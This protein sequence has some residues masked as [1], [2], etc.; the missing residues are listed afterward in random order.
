M[1]LQLTL[2]Q[3]RSREKAAD[4]FVKSFKM[5]G[6]NVSPNTIAAWRITFYA[7]WDLG[8]ATG[9]LAERVGRENDVGEK[10]ANKN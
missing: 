2:E 6:A 9:R 4:V 3:Q 8:F 1:K 5:K 10:S 7:I